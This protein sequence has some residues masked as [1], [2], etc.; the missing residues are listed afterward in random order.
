M[1]QSAFRA[2]PLELWNRP[3]IDT[4]GKVLVAQAI[5]YEHDDGAQSF[6]N[7]RSLLMSRRV[8]GLRKSPT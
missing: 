3:R 8:R 5:G 1:V 6:C 4:A 7:A 2:H